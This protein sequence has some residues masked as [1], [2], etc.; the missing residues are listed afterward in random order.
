MRMMSRVGRPAGAL[1]LAGAIALSCAPARAQK[2]PADSVEAFYRGKTINLVI[3]SNPGGGYDSYGRMVARRLGAHIPGH[4]LVTPMNMAGA[5]GG[6]AAGYVAAV[7]PK[8]GA[9]LLATLTG[10]FLDPLI[11]AGRLAYDA[12]RFNYLGSVDGEAFACA[13][14]KD[15][16]VKTFPDALTQETLLGVSGGSTRD[17]PMLLNGVLGAKFKL[18]AGY[19]GTR[20]VTLAMDRG[21]AQGIC[22]MA[23]GSMR[24]AAAGLVHAGLPRAH[25]GAGGDA[26]RPRLRSAG[27]ADGARFAATAEDRRA[28]ELVYAQTE[29]TRPFAVAPD[30]PADRVAAL[31]AAFAETLADPELAAEARKRSLAV[32]PMSGEALTQAIARLYATPPAIVARVR[33]ALAGP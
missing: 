21:E 20:E 17:F 29:F 32:S 13:L 19:P 23:I 33:A 9:T 24:G 4:P 25:P 5:G 11:G 26:P 10:A 28:M 30:V 1:S 18:V 7:A 14:R 31:R 22:G 27:R 12:T 16:A 6:V 2:L 8:D 15:A 3:G